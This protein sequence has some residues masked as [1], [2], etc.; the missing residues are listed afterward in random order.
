MIFIHDSSIYDIHPSSIIPLCEER[1]CKQL[2]TLDQCS[3]PQLQDYGRVEAHARWGIPSSNII[4]NTINII[5]NIIIMIIHHLSSIIQNPTIVKK[6]DVQISDVNNHKSD[7]HNANPYSSANES[8]K[9]CFPYKWATPPGSKIS[10]RIQLGQSQDE[11]IP[12]T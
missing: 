4:I 8:T 11:Q 6:Y 5:I 12:R 1:G 7:A 3:W 9:L 10:I 2:C